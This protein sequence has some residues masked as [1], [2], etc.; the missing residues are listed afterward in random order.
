MGKKEEPMPRIAPV[1]SIYQNPDHI[2]GLMQQNLRCATCHRRN[3]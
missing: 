3:T 2:A 1:V